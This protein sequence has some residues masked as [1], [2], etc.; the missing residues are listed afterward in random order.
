MGSPLHRPTFFAPV[1]M[2]ALSHPNPTASARAQVAMLKMRQI[3]IA[4]IQAA[5]RGA[6]EA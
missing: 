5:L 1:L 4:G 3:H 2:E 6:P